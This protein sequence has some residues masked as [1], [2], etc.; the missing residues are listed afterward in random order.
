MRS[1]WPSCAL[2]MPSAALVQ[3]LHVASVFGA[4]G[5]WSVP[6]ACEPVRISC[7]FGLSPTPMMTV[8]FSVSAVSFLMLLL[9]E[10]R[11]ATLLAI[12][13]PFWLYQGPLPMRS[14]AFTA[15]CPLAAAALRYACHVLPRL[16]AAVARFWQILS[17][18]AR[19]PRL[20]P[21]PDPTLLTKKL[22]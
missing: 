14:L 4:V 18:P 8:P 20:A 10:C 17:P 13:T 2:P 7:W 12:A 1:T 9:S 16:P 22:I 6:S 11:S 5:G 3:L 21:F 19:P 15:G